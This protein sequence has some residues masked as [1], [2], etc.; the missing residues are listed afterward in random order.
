M[1][2]IDYLDELDEEQKY[3]VL[4]HLF[5][6]Y[7]KNPDSFPEDQK[8]LLE[9]EMMKLYQKAEMEGVL[10][11][12]DNYEEYS[13]MEDSAMLKRKRKSKSK[14]KK[15]IKDQQYMNQL[16]QQHYLQQLALQQQMYNQPI[17]NLI[18]IIEDCM[19]KFE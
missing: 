14:Q 16:Q 15:R 19:N 6:E 5:E 10:D 13:E 3:M 8:Q 17:W 12:D 7:Q 18:V 1:V 4:Q 11:D 9:H 2:I